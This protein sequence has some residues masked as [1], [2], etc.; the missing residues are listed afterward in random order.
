MNDTDD[1]PTGTDA[2]TAETN[3][4]TGIGALALG[5]GGGIVVGGAVGV[6]IGQPMI[7]LGIGIALGV[8][9]TAG[10]LSVFTDEER[11]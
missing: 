11:E 1:E 2:D 3:W 9:V 10:L 7:W 4:K 8:V 6:A 5:L